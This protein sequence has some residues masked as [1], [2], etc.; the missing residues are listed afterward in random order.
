M[1][2]RNGLLIE[3][4]V[5]SADG[6][7]ERKSARAMLETELPG[8]RRI[9]LAADKGYDTGEFVA[10]CR[11]LKVTPHIAR[12][13]RRAGGSA[14]DRRTRASYRLRGEPKGAQAG[15]RDLRLD[16][17]R[18]R[19]AQNSLSRPRP[20]QLHAYLV[21]AAYNLPP[22]RQTQPGLRMKNDSTTPPRPPRR[23]K[24]VEP[25]D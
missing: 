9:T 11:A 12:N 20:H 16:E 3:F 17:D 19:P 23:A 21:A 7:A 24:T 14:L 5:E 13:E 6:Y 10:A 18:G 2:N 15:R 22:N 1:E 8:S 4:T 25:S